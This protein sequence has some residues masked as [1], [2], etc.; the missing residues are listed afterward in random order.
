MTRH[1]SG[2]FATFFAVFVVGHATS[3]TFAAE[4]AVPRDVDRVLW[5]LPTDTESIIVARGPLPSRRPEKPLRIEQ[6]IQNGRP[7]TVHVD[8]ETG[9]VVSPHSGPT[10][11]QLMA[12]I[13]AVEVTSLKGIKQQERAKPRVRLAIAAGRKFKP[14][15]DIPGGPSVEFCQIVVF[16]RKVRA[17]MLAN[18]AKRAR[19]THEIVG[20][21]V[22]E[23]DKRRDWGD[24]YSSGYFFQPAENILVMSNDIDFVA[25]M[26]KRKAVRARSRALP[27]DLAEWKYVDTKAATWG[28]HHLRGLVGGKHQGAIIYSWDA[29]SHAVNLH[30]VSRAP[31]RD[32]IASLLS[33]E[34]TNRPVELK[35]VGD[36]AIRFSVPVDQRPVDAATARIGVMSLMGWMANL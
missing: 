20:V 8:P 27:A 24:A 4:T 32:E 34:L 18:L 33:K 11:T 21:H 3:P 7:V 5:W 15:T 31:N 26:L 13:A 25:T 22:F 30:F 35:S 9:K 2:I 28:V 1:A 36:D 6:R 16:D 17:D 29:K 23:L 10:F 19:R 14:P 12:E